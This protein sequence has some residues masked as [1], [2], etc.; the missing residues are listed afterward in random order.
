MI[1]NYILTSIIFLFLGCG[2]T[3]SEPTSLSSITS[4]P[5]N[6][7][8]LLT[9][10]EYFFTKN[11]NAT[12]RELWM[13]DGT[14][15]HL[16]KDIQSDTKSSNIRDLIAFKD[17]FL[18]AADDG[19]HGMELFISD[20][21]SENTFMLKDLEPGSNASYPSSFTIFNEKVYFTTEDALW[22]SK[23]FHFAIKL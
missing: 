10:Q 3:N 8:P 15:M 12:G 19:V 18:F 13:T 2:G 5:S 4:N 14:E 16:V 21:T 1:K 6:N 23:I 20:G 11:D 9:G 7:S 22:C 17:K